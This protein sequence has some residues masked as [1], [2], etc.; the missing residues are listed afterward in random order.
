MDKRFFASFTPRARLVLLLIAAA[1]AHGAAA[2][3]NPVRTRPHAPAPLAVPQ[4]VIVKLRALAAPPA[5]DQLSEPAAR[6]GALTTR[7]GVRLLGQRPITARL[8]ALTLEPLAGESTGAVLARLRADADVEYAVPDERR[9][10]HGAPNDPLYTQQWY[11]QVAAA[12]PSAVDAVDAWGVTTGS[13]TLVI[14]DID[15]GVRTDHPDLAGKLLPGYCFISVAFVANG[16]TCPGPGADDPGDW[17]TSTDITANP[18]ECSNQTAAPSSWHGT[19]VAGLLSAATNNGAGVA[20]V[21]WGSPILPVRALGKCGG[22]DSDI[23]TGMLWAGGVAVSGAPVNPNPARIINMSLGGAGACLTSYVDAIAQ[24]NALGVLVVASAGNEGGQVDAPANCP[25]VA[26]VAGLRQAGTKVGYSSLGPE[27]ALGAPAG[28]C[29]DSF[30]TAESACVYSMMTTTNL[31]AMS[32]G[33]PDANDYTGL[34]YCDAT[35]GSYPGCTIAAGQYRTYSIGTSFSAPVVSGIAAL[36]STVNSNLNSCQLIARL[37][38]GAQPYPQSSLDATG[39]QPPMCHV[40]ASATDLQESECICTR[41]DQTCGAGMANAPGA[42]TAALRPIAAVAVPAS[43]TA[44]QTLTL[45]GSGSGAANGHSLASYQWSP[46]SGGLSLSITGAATS[47]AT[48]TGPSC[49]VGTV[50]LTVTDDAGHSDSAEVVITP[51]SATTSAPAAA[52]QNACAVS[53]AGIVVAVCPASDNVRT[54]ATETLTATLANTSNAAVTWEVNG[55]A[56]GNAALGTITS[57][58]VY[59]APASVP[60]PA[61]VTITAVSQADASATGASQLTITAPGGGGGGGGGLDP[62]TLLAGAVLL[63]ARLLRRRRC[64]SPA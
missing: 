44:G 48:L 61:T 26:G 35:S 2:E 46:V 27:V 39:S 58:G 33:T 55:I 43:V 31:S 40:P 30:T 16:A 20:G 57:A 60:A 54:G 37:K 34:Y 1:T 19:R 63:A 6:L 64:A 49:G 62:G 25:G 41:D 36:M 9:Y 24:L 15:T 4:R 17:V 5:T 23:I 22:L 45:D 28:N 42:L 18:N 59:S 14:A 53:A 10:I 8:H 56:G 32:P 11:L 3:L 52:G 38:E 21:T 13:T 47:K 51:D 7:S 50:A 12:T 29:G